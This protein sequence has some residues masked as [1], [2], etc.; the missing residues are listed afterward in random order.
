MLRSNYKKKCQEFRP[1]NV[2][3]VYKK[4]LELVVMEQLL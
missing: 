1:I 3:L 4:R 2:V